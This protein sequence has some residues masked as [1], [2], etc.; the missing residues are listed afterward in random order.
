MPKLS[1]R[2]EWLN[3]LVLEYQVTR[4]DTLFLR[5]LEEFDVL[6]YAISWKFHEYCSESFKSF[7]DIMKSEFFLQVIDFDPSRSKKFSVYIC[8]KLYQVALHLKRSFDIRSS[9]KV[10]YDDLNPVPTD[11]PEEVIYSLVLDDAI[12]DCLNDKGRHILRLYYFKGYTQ[13]QISQ[14]MGLSQ[15]M[16]SYILK[17]SRL[18]L[19]DILKNSKGLLDG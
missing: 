8:N 5:L 15:G 18:H 9:R 17:K 2:D 4:D 7:L 1:R 14:Q 12:L 6:F 16:V 10:A 13:S 19:Y 3:R 11:I